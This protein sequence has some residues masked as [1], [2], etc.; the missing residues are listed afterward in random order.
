MSRRERRVSDGEDFDGFAQRVSRVSALA[1]PIRRALYHFVAHQPGAVSRDQAAAG[2][3]IPR[4][5]AKFHLDK[6]VDEGLLVPEFRRLTGRSGPGAGRPA[7]LY[8]RVRKEV[9]VTLPRRR[10]D[11]AGHVLAD[12]LE[13]VKAGTPL[14]RAIEEAA[15]NAAGIVVRSW[16]PVESSDVDRM[17]GLLARLGYEPRPD[18][19]GVRLSNCPFQ[20]LSDD[21]AGLICPINRQFIDAVSRQLACTEVHPTSVDRGTGCCVALVPGPSL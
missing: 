8:R 6:L 21:H 13:R 15:D 20:Q 16:P 3:D 19:D 4:H 14:D 10:Y 12:T 5:T 7:K 11:L 2:L 17:A 18:G 1:D 9:N